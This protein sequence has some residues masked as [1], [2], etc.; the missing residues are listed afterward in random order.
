M[1]CITSDGEIFVAFHD[2]SS[3]LV[4][5]VTDHFSNDP[6][7]TPIIATGHQ[8]VTLCRLICAQ[9][10]AQIL[11]PLMSSKYCHRTIHVCSLA[12]VH[13]FLGFS[14]D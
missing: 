10:G 4:F 5:V 2:Y 14:Q 11:E 12:C 3:F 6:V 13:H 8:L 7:A 9:E 1:V